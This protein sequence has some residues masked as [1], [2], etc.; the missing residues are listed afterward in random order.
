MVATTRI[1]PLRGADAELF[2]AAR[3]RAARQQ[4]YLAAAIF[5]LVPV[6]TPGLGTFGVDRFWRVYVDMDTARGWGIA[7]T[8]SVLVHE[9]HHVIRDHHDRARRAG[10]TLS[11]HHDWNLAADAAINDDLLTDGLPLPDP[12]LP[13]HIGCRRGGFEEAYFRA[14]LRRPP[15]GRSARCGSGSGGSV[16]D[17]EIDETPGS[18]DEGL[19]TVD[20]DA[21]RRG[22]AHEVLQADEQ[23]DDVPPSL[24]LWARALVQPQVPWSQLLRATIGRGLRA[25]VRDGEPD[26][27]RPDRRA[28]TSTEV[29][30]PGVRR[31]R[32][33]VVVVIDTSASMEQRQLS[34]AVAEIDSLLHRAGVSPIDVVVC[35]EE[36]VRPQRIHRLAG[37]ELSGGR[38]TDMTVGI[39][40]AAAVR[41]TPK[42]IVVLTDGE[43]CWPAS[44]PRGIAVIVVLIDAPD[45][46]PA[47]P[48]GADYQVVRVTSGVGAAP[49]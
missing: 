28:G 45:R 42:V 3:L 32:P 41:P 14:V 9:A 10:V 49:T 40:V 8:A 26:W 30:R 6:A 24:V 34:A 23:G 16:L 25:A 36:A 47:P 7:A 29:L 19:D 35:D 33:R 2:A 39:A 20:A 44:P 4:P 11:T 46:E 1:T 22:V 5:A 13:R 17:V 21:V 48:P 18:P 31:T 38:G 37:L 15:E 12:V 43:T 27:G